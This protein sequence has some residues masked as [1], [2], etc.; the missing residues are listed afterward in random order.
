MPHATE[1]SL[2]AELLKRLR[3]E[4]DIIIIDGP[5][6]LGLADAPLL[7]SAAN[8]VMFVVESGKPRT[9]ARHGGR[10]W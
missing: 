8:H 5:P 7:A 4:F 6:T 9:R 10:R 1:N 2:L 3:A